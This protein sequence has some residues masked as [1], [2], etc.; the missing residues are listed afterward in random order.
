[1][2]LPLSEQPALGERKGSVA[3]YRVVDTLEGGA[4]V[5]EVTMPLVHTSGT[6]TATLSSMRRPLGGTI[7]RETRGLSSIE[8]ACVQRWLTSN[9]T[10]QEAEAAL[11]VA[12]FVRR[13]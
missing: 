11:K 6:R 12:G 5:A 3:L 2:Y 8:S 1:M 10:R 13:L 9:V 4:S 7:V